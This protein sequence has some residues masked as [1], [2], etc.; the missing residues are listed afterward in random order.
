MRSLSWPMSDHNLHRGVRIAFDAFHRLTSRRFRQTRITMITKLSQ[1]RPR[2]SAELL[3]APYATLL[4]GV[5]SNPLGP[6]VAFLAV[7]SSTSLPIRGTLYRVVLNPFEQTCDEVGSVDLRL[8]WDEAVGDLADS[9]EGLLGSCPAMVVVNSQVSEQKRF[10]VITNWL[11]SF[12]NGGHLMHLIE[13]NLGL[14]WDR[15]T[16]ELQLATQ[17]T[18]Q[19][20]TASEPLSREK[21]F[22]FANLI[23]DPKHFQP[24]LEALVESWNGAIQQAKIGNDTMSAQDLMKW[25][26]ACFSTCTVPGL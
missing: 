22:E 17:A 11:S 12:P 16:A 21:A 13:A 1:P 6:T 24:E 3:S 2:G 25:L 7:P 4:V 20:T 10:A 15:F 18:H 23:S 9:S 8:P 14:P 26:V 5:I 19:S